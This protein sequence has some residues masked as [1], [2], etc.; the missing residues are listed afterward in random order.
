MMRKQLLTL[1]KLAERDVANCGSTL[2][3]SAA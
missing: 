1:G 2:Q 3:P